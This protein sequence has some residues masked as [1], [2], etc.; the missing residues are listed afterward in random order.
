V[1]EIGSLHDCLQQIIVPAFAAGFGGEHDVADILGRIQIEIGSQT[2]SAWPHAVDHGTVLPPKVCLNWQGQIGDL[3]CLAHEC[4]HVLQFELSKHDTM[5]PVAREICAFLG[6][7][8]LL[9]YVQ[10]HAPKLFA[11]VRQIWALE[12]HFYLVEDLDVL[13]DALSDLN[14]PYHYRHNY[15][16]ARLAAVYLFGRE[17][18]SV[19]G[20][21]ES[22]SGAMRF[23]PFDEMAKRTEKIRNYLPS[24]PVPNP[25][26][27]LLRVHRSVGAAVLLDLEGNTSRAGSNLGE[28]FFGISAHLEEGTAFIW[29]SA[30][31][32]PMGYATWHNTPD[33]HTAEVS[34]QIAPFGGHVNLQALLECRCGSRTP[35]D[36]Y[37]PD[38]VVW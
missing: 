11:P 24:F 26:T 8:L 34:H 4:A 7:L 20:F 16:L 23:L 3:V 28:Y 22:G 35:G 38:I 13:W 2:R 14:S 29:L 19:P 32:K 27:P 31:R 12:N 6:E 9:N 37:E 5:P 33:Q 10:Q 30:D 25:E 15:P 17:E 21:F 18:F 1:T 36:R